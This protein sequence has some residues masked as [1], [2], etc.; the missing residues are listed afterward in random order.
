M[1]D[2]GGLGA[3]KKMAKRRLDAAGFVQSECCEI[4]SDKRMKRQQMALQLAAS[5]AELYNLDAEEKE[6]QHAKEMDELIPLA[7]KALQKLKANNMNW[8]K[9]TVK[10]IQS[11]GLVHFNTE[12]KKQKKDALV[13]DAQAMLQNAQSNIKIQFQ[14][15]VNN[16]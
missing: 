13:K 3:T 10:E 8:N 2:A 11:I 1:K 6:A 4:T 12:L 7:P 5:L 15:N 16:A 14:T 9:I